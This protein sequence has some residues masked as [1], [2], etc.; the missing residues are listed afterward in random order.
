MKEGVVAEKD[1]S[2]MKE[3]ALCLQGGE[4]S[5]VKDDNLT[6]PLLAL[7][8]KDEDECSQSEE[9]RLAEFRRFVQKLGGVLVTMSLL[10]LGIAYAQDERTLTLIDPSFMFL[11][12]GFC[13]GSIIVMRCAMRVIN[14]DSLV[15]DSLPNATIDRLENASKAWTA[16]FMLAFFVF[17]IFW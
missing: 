17:Y 16:C 14:C 12:Y 4:E 1:Y 8:A 11:I 3:E 5:T 6:V 15:C 2:R 7:S 13:I 10:F 9:E